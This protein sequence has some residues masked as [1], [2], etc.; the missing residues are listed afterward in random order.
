MKLVSIKLFTGLSKLVILCE[1]KSG[2]RWGKSSILDKFNQNIFKT[3]KD[4]KDGYEF[5]N[6]WN[7]KSSMCCDLIIFAKTK[8]IKKILRKM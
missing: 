4:K 7:I 1:T 2:S 8:S 5:T 6:F 3:Y